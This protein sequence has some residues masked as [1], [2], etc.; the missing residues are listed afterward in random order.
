MH[1][2]AL[3]IRGQ[4]HP[5]FNYLLAYIVAHFLISLPYDHILSSSLATC[6]QLAYKN[7][8]GQQY[9]CISCAKCTYLGSIFI[10]HS[11]VL[12]LTLFTTLETGYQARHVVGW[13]KCITS[14]MV[15]VGSSH[16]LIASSP[17]RTAGIRSWIWAN[18]ECASTVMTV[19]V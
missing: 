14:C 6:S 5:N 16:A 13:S 3:I 11:G 15:R 7:F 4:I 19:Y 12:F 9:N 10:M 2:R 8:S 1:N 18:V 17:S